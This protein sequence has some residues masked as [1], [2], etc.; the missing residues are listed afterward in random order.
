M[1]VRTNIEPN[2]SQH[3]DILYVISQLSQLYTL[4]GAYAIG[5]Y[6]V[7]Q[8]GQLY[9]LPTKKYLPNNTFITTINII[10]NVV[11]NMH[12][13]TAVK[14]TKAGAQETVLLQLLRET[15]FL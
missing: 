9:Y 7:L 15:N 14:I 10:N 11:L 4:G 3:P 8:E 12:I 6:L 13:K 2:S 1:K 5:R